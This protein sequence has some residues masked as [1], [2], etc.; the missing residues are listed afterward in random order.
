MDISNDINSD[1]ED[2]IS[3]N[4]DNKYKLDIDINNVNN[5]NIKLVDWV[6]N[7]IDN[8]RL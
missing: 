4:E 7:E 1:E 8:R 6:D 2:N 3:S 5:V